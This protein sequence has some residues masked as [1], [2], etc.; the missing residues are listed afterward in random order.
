M[1]SSFAIDVVICTYERGT[2][3]ADV[4]R[5]VRDQLGP[6]DRVL[7][8]DQSRSVQGLFDEVAQIGDGR[9]VAIAAPARGL[10]AAR[11]LAI[12][13]TRGELLLF[14]DDDVSVS[15]SLLSAHRAAY[16]DPRVGGCVGW[17]DERAMAWNAKKTQNKVDRSGRVR[18]RLD[19]DAACEVES[20]KGCNMSIRRAA[21]GTGPSFDEGYRGTSFLEETDLSTRLRRAGWRLRFIPDARVVHF[22]VAKGGVRQAS[23]RAAEHWRFHNTGRYLAKHRGLGSVL[24]AA[25]IFGAIAARRAWEWG[26]AGEAWRLLGALVSG[27][28]H[29]PSSRDRRDDVRA[30]FTRSAR[31]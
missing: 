16:A 1:T 30:F 11:N 26:D 23:R 10:P 21:L 7:L 22:G 24:L 8:I 4:A 9:I 3:A 20:L 27:G 12:Q 25:P 5:G 19:G 15:P 18:V 29:A 31:R 17:I 28:L 2:L 13:R 14:L 6:D